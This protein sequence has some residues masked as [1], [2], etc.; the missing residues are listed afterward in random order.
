MLKL[1]EEPP[2]RSLILIVSHRPGQVL[3]TIRSRC[4]RLLVEPLQ[5]AEIVEIVSGLGEPWSGMEPAA[6]LEAAGRADGSLREAMRRLDP[7]AQ[8]VG[9]LIDAAISRLPNPDMK[10]VHKLADAVSGRA[11]TDKFEALTLALYDWIA[12]RGRENASPAR[13]EMLASL[14]ERVRAATRETDALNLDRRL[15]VIAMFEEIAARARGI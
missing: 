15:H 2:P 7:D 12:A 8:G 14:W 11:A 9:A 3:P 4:R 1:I 13:L 5:P 6:V 10:L